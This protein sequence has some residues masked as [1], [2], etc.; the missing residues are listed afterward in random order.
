MQPSVNDH[1]VRSRTIAGKKKQPK[2]IYDRN[3]PIFLDEEFFKFKVVPSKSKLEP[4]KEKED[5]VKKNHRR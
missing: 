2:I 4:P 1:M 3:R 5:A